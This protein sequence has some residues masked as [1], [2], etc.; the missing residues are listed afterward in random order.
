VP[1]LDQDLV[2]LMAVCPPHLMAAQRGSAILKDIARELLPAEIVDRP[3]GYFPV[4]ATTQLDGPV[5]DMVRDALRSATATS[6]GLLRRDY[7]AVLLDAPNANMTRVGGNTL[8]DI[9]VLEMWLQQHHT[10]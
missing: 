5:L 9:A 7:V 10:S 2:E 3:K 1:F 4:R 6:R 8:W